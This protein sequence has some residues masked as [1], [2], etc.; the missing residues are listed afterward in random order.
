MILKREM[1]IVDRLQEE[2]DNY[3]FLFNNTDEVNQFKSD[4]L[5]WTDEK[6]SLPVLS[7]LYS[8]PGM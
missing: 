7:S 3:P 4:I 2:L 8:Y 6:I 5:Q 1:E